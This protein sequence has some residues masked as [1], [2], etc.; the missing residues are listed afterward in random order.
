MLTASDRKNF[1][2]YEGKMKFFF[3]KHEIDTETSG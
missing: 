2:K 1:K 3:K